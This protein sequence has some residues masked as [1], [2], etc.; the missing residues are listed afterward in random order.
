MYYLGEHS[1]VVK[2]SGPVIGI[3]KLKIVSKWG[4][5][6]LMEHVADDCPYSTSSLSLWNR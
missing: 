2:H 4:K 1:G 6:P 5:G 3:E